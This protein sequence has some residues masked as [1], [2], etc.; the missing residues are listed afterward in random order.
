MSVLGPD[1]GT[2]DG[3]EHCRAHHPSLA[4]SV[5]LVYVGRNLSS[6]IFLIP[7]RRR[8]AVADARP[9]GTGSVYG[10]HDVFAATTN[11]LP[12][13]RAVREQQCD[14]CR[15]HYDHQPPAG[16][17]LHDNGTAGWEVVSIDIA[18]PVRVSENGRETGVA[19][20]PDTT[21]EPDARC[22]NHRLNDLSPRGAHFAQSS[23]T[24]CIRR[25]GINVEP[26]PERRI[27][28]RKGV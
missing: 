2:G 7:L 24:V 9:S 19:L 25:G 12:P 28:R 8:F 18:D 20:S 1:S 5:D 16:S 11:P 14:R 10:P 4:T 17:G 21:N 26:D 27:R 13:E 6:R 22:G 3:G 23:E 15:A